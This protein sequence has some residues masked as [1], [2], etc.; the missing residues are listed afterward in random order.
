MSVSQR[1][2][3]I[4]N[5]RCIG[6]DALEGAPEILH[7]YNVAIDV[8]EDL[9][10]R[11]GLRLREEIVQPLGAPLVA[12]DLRLVAQSEFLRGF[13]GAFVRAKEND[14]DLRMKRLPGLQRVAL[15]D[16]MWPRKGFAVVKMVSMFKHQHGHRSEDRPLQEREYS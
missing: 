2:P 3:T 16:P 14:F 7:Q 11:Y 10:P 1:R 4:R 5:S 9:I 13:G 6:A 15:N 8:A 12:L